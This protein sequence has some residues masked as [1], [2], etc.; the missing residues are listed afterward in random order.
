MDSYLWASPDPC[1]SS[2]IHDNVSNHDHSIVAE[3]ETMEG[4]TS[5]DNNNFSCH[6]HHQHSNQ[7]L[8]YKKNH[9]N[10]TNNRV[11]FNLYLFI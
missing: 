8:Y 3:E 7:G 1:R 6:Y 2:C 10:N 11:T 4:S 5:H 9:E